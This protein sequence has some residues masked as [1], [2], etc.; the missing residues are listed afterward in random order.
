M[1]HAWTSSAAWP[2]CRWKWDGAATCACSPLIAVFGNSHWIG[3]KLS[4][5]IRKCTAQSVATIPASVAAW[6]SCQICFSS[7]VCSQLLLWEPVIPEAFES[8]GLRER[9]FPCPGALLQQE[10]HSPSCFMQKMTNDQLVCLDCD[11]SWPKKCT[12]PSVQAKHPTSLN[13]LGMHF[14]FMQSCY[15]N[16]MTNN[17][18]LQWKLRR[19]LQHSGCCC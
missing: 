11:S 1:L 3:Q 13:G 4:R 8:T 12:L 14:C 17:E 6:E 18:W 16:K 2:P 5:S 15:M 7:A 19:C 10:V 9:S